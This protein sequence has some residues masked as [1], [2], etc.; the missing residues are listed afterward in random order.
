[1]KNLPFLVQSFEGRGK[2]EA[3]TYQWAR[4][5]FS[6]RQWE[7]REEDPDGCGRSEATADES[8]HVLGENQQIIT[9]KEMRGSGTRSQREMSA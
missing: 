3:G 9:P 6:L 2:I 5:P 1:M 7:R 8:T 4:S